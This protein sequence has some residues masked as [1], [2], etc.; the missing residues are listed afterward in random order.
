[1]KLLYVADP[2]C[3]WCWGFSPVIRT[4]AERFAGRAPLEVVMGGLRPGTTTPM[5]EA[6]RTAIREHWEHVRQASGQPFDFSFFSRDGFIY[7]TEPA[8]R[9]V[10]T[11]RSL[12]PPVALD[13]L[14]RV[15]A[16]FYRD[17]LDVTAPDTLADVAEACGLD[18]DDFLTHFDAPET[19]Q[20]TR[21]DF[22]RAAQLGARGFPTL[23]GDDG[24][25]RVGLSIGYQPSDSLLPKVEAWVGE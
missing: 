15:Q 5:D 18:R 2:M 24:V 8:C 20:A 1:M 11:A 21:S 19:L 23:I 25:R 9:A 10:V 7:D 16:A 17:N 22:G 13:F 12:R 4:V 6:M 14:A 3:S